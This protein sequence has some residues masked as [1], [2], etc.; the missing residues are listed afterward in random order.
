MRFELQETLN[1]RRDCK[2]GIRN[3][4]QNFDDRF[5]R[6][7]ERKERRILEQRTSSAVSKESL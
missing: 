6:I 4:F 3:H 2:C 1:E 7:G 5:V